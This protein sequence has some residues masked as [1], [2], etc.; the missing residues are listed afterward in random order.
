[1]KASTYTHTYKLKNVLLAV[2]KVRLFIFCSAS[3][4]KLTNLERW[5]IVQGDT[6]LP[7]VR[8]LSALSRRVLATRLRLASG[9]STRRSTLASSQFGGAPAL[10]AAAMST[11]SGAGLGK[12]HQV[13]WEKQRVWVKGKGD[14]LPPRYR[15]TSPDRQTCRSSRVCFCFCFFPKPQAELL[16]MMC[17]TP[18]GVPYS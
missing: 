11:A 1:M 14:F 18:V 12:N 2:V 8:A 9:F 6:S 3:L 4:E 17:D 5:H 10:K 7:S 13:I 15:C 16:T